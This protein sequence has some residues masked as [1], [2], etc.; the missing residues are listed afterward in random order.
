MS[1]WGHL[2]SPLWCWWTQPTPLY[3]VRI[4]FN[5]IPLPMSRC[6]EQSLHC[7]VRELNP[8]PV[9]HL[10]Q[11]YKMWFE[12]LTAVIR[13]SSELKRRVLVGSHLRSGGTYCLLPQCLQKLC[14]SS[15]LDDPA[16]KMT[17][18]ELVCQAY[19]GSWF[20]DCFLHKPAVCSFADRDT[21][22]GEGQNVKCEVK[23]HAHGRRPGV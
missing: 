21:G 14:I 19:K 4:C 3:F 10:I 12:I 16:G 6:F 8:L 20:C 23:G 22:T 2:W 13:C 18:K 5:I 17:S 9:L 7:K 15:W 1:I 11:D